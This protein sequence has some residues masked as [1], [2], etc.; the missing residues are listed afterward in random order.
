MR[1][2]MILGGLLW[3]FGA[4]AGAGQPAAVF[5]S[6][7]ADGISG[8]PAP[9]EAAAAKR[10]PFS[11]VGLGGS[12][13]SREYIVLTDGVIS[14]VA[15]KGDVVGNRYRIEALTS[16]ALAV[17]D[18]ATGERH[19]IIPYKQIQHRVA[20]AAPKEVPVPVP[21]VS[22]QRPREAA[23]PA[24]KSRARSSR[25]MRRAQPVS[26]EPADAQAD[27]DESLQA[28]VAPP[29][30]NR[31]EQAMP[32][33]MTPPPAGNPMVVTAA[34]RDI[35]MITTPSRREHQAP[36]NIPLGPGN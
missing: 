12:G 3:A 32:M 17:T 4:T 9:E 5:S 29:P 24:Y 26:I 31:A 2:R 34:P 19:I 35:P 36:V 27:G 8:A 20:E 30:V 18:L 21:V 28:M 13:N 23:A 7:G 16:R 1:I 25:T 22:Y 10:F 6:H 11:L 15:L 14:L 33:E